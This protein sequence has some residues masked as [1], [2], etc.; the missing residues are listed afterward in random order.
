M[1]LL[2]D[3]LI[4]FSVVFHGLTKYPPIFTYKQ[5]KNGSYEFGGVAKDLLDVAKKFLNMR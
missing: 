3:K 1:H 4:I 5:Q 2:L